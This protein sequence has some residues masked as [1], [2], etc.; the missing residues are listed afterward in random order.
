MLPTDIPDPA[1]VRAARALHVGIPEAIE[2]RDLGALITNLSGW[3]STDP[4]VRDAALAPT[5]P[6]PDSPKETPNG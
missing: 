3:L 5:D 2:G 6:S 1:A 4:A